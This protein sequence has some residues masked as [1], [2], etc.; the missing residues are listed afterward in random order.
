[1]GTK[2]PFKTKIEI[3]HPWGRPI[4]HVLIDE[5]RLE[6]L[7]FPDKKLYRGA[8]TPE[9]LSTFFPGDFDSDLILAALRGYPNLLRHHKIISLKAHQISLLNQGG[10]EVEII[11]FYPESLLPKRVSLPEHHINLAFSD[12]QENDGVYYA[13]EVRVDD[14]KGKKKLILQSKK[15]VFNKIIPEQIFV[16]EKPPGFQTS[17]LPENR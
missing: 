2:Y 8:F 7:S 5:T 1:M 3:T 15:M 13:R 6:V 16:L 12:F 4:L 14:F 11:D 17:P 9:A 10:K